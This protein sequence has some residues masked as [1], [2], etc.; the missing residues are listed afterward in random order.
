MSTKQQDIELKQLLK[1]HLRGKYKFVTTLVL[2]KLSW[3]WHILYSYYI[4]VSN[5]SF[6]VFLG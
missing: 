1:M 5:A 3:V 2:Q 4:S 6:R